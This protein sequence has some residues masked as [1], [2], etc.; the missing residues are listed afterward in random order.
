MSSSTAAGE[1]RGS[2]LRAAV[3]PLALIGHQGCAHWA[4]LAAASGRVFV[5][6]YACRSPRYSW[7]SRVTLL[8]SIRAFDRHRA[9]AAPAARSQ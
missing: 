3:A 1:A 7:F 4:T 9:S 6:E 8:Q 2:A 5:L